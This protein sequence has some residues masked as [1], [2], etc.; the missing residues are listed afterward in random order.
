MDKEKV[1]T[2]D[3]S[4]ITNNKEINTNSKDNLSSLLDMKGNHTKNSK[5]KSKSEKENTLNLGNDDSLYDNMNNE[6]MKIVEEAELENLYNK[7]QQKIEKKLDKKRKTEE[8]TSGSNL[9]INQNKV[10][11]A[12]N[13]QN[14]Q[15]YKEEESKY[16]RRQ[17]PNREIKETKSN[18]S[19]GNHSKNYNNNSNNN[20]KV[21]VKLKLTKDKNDIIDVSSKKSLLESPRDF[22]KGSTGSLINNDN[23]NLNNK[24]K[25]IKPLNNEP[26]DIKQFINED[27][28]ENY[29]NNILTFKRNTNNL[30]STNSN[31]FSNKLSDSLKQSSPPLSPISKGI[32]SPQSTVKIN[33]NDQYVIDE[34]D[35]DVDD[36]NDSNYNENF[37]F[38]N[39]IGILI[40]RHDLTLG[41][42]EELLKMKSSYKTKKIQRGN[43]GVIP[44]VKKRMASRPK[45]P[46]TINNSH[47]INTLN[48]TNGGKFGFGYTGY[49]QGSKDNNRT[50]N[51][52][53]Y[54]D[55]IPDGLTSD[56]V[57][58]KRNNSIST[59]RKQS[60]Y[61]KIENLEKP[62]FITKMSPKG[63]K[64]NSKFKKKAE[65]IEL[66]SPA[67]VFVDNCENSLFMKK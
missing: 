36:M 42:M 62:G 59:H 11:Y 52:D 15:Y 64:S 31:H 14:N 40:N 9:S 1:V 50:E 23:H 67:K 57:Q 5:N 60:N 20:S 48:I 44:N 37:V 18:K 43:I 61:E 4:K 26:I 13:N 65:I 19:P 53:I 22:G 27:I 8:S 49:G 54:F 10:N 7:H 12:N 34:N 29:N 17:T 21:N 28:M 58:H 55:N 24:D 6:N 39:K 41:E 30:V 51:K 33:V 25:K 35:I 46:K 3:I 45:T 63:N 2:S 32:N 66:K 56:I 47:T 16:K 38:K